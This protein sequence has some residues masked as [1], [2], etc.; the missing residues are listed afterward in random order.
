MGLEAVLGQ[1]RSE[2]TQALITDGFTQK[3]QI[4]TGWPTAPQLVEILGQPDNEY[5]ISIFPFPAKNATRYV[6][7]RGGTYKAPVP[8][9]TSFIDET[10]TVLTFGGAAVNAQNIHAFLALH[11][12]DA[13]VAAPA[14]MTPPQA[15]AAVAAYVNAASLKGV[16]ATAIGPSVTLGG[17]MWEICN[18]GG[19]GLITSGETLRTSR[20]VQVSIWTTG[21]LTGTDPDGSLRLAMYDSISS[22]IGTVANHFFTLPDGSSAYVV[23][24]GDNFMDDAQS[25][26]SLYVAKI[27]LYLE[28]ALFRSSAATQVGDI[29]ASTTI[30]QSTTTTPIGGE[31]E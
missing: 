26:Y 14:G 2:I 1:L 31:P 9:L 11:D 22:Q 5:Q 15:A 30:G 27:Y 21:G 17:D 6:G 19:S 24:Q 29:V 7:E 3:G 20:M 10:E 23:F 25:S 18:I 16:S 28:Y 12:V 4:I 8:G 13:Y